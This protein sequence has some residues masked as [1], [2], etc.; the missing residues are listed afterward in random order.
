MKILIIAP[1]WV[2][3]M[4]MAQSLF[5]LLKKNKP[6]CLIHVM[7]LAW[8][9]PLLSRMPEVDKIID[10]PLGH[11]KLDIKTRYQLGKSLRHEK[12]DQTILL[13]NTLKSA[14]IP[15]WADIPKR[16]GFTGEIRYGLLN[17]RRTLDK[18]ILS[19]TV[20]R[21]CALAYD[22]NDKQI[23]E[24]IKLENIPTPLLNIEKENIN[25]TLEQFNL[26]P[27]KAILGL[28][29]GAEYG[30]AKQ[31]PAEYYAEVALE[32]IKN[33][34]QVWIF[35]S[36]KDN[37][38]AA[39]INQQTENQCINLCGQT[40]LGQAI[41]LMSLSQWVI[42][43]DSGLMH[44]AAAVGVP[45]IGIYGSTDPNFTPPLG[46]QSATIT[47]NLDCSPCFKRTCPLGHNH[48]LTQLT[49][50]LVKSKIAEFIK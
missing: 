46:N 20:Q 2:G 8:S 26:N 12:Y 19:M 10:M 16:T 34:G 37:E 32:Y 33:N 14:L 28:C 41:D 31:W 27:D 24:K 11:G 44:M 3:D 7:A 25:K 39:I 13:P 47:L 35:G 4:I 43:N 5:I 17:D 18:Q 42:S 23:S 29:P 9:S 1:S 15:Y 6:N 49:P 48:C 30:P 50:D 21:F 36:E 40:R 38:I 45:I 22:K